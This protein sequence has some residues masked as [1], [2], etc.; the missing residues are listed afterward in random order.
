MGLQDAQD[1]ILPSL[2]II[3]FG[4]Q[5]INLPPNFV[6]LVST[7]LF[8][9]I[10]GL[11]RTEL[12]VNLCN[13]LA[14]ELKAFLARFVLFALEGVYLDFELEFAPLELVNSLW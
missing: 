2:G 11:E 7:F 13:G 9:L 3:C 6:Q 4:F 14:R 10:S 1:R 12:F 8:V 5:I